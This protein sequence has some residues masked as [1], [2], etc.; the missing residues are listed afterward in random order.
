[1]DT[2]LSMAVGPAHAVTEGARRATEVTACAGG[3]AA[4]PGR[5]D[6]EVREKQ[7]Y[8]RLTAEYKLRILREADACEPGKIAAL[9]R[10]EGLYSSHLTRWREQRDRGVLDALVSRKRGRKEDADRLL[11]KK[12]AVQERENERLKKRLKQA[13]MIIEVQKKVSEM[14]G[15][16]LESSENGGRNE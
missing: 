6:P 4:G 15:I 5:P 9:L 1:M 8:R 3:A 14:L 7:A 13:E 10:R 2:A 11:R 16:S 12:L